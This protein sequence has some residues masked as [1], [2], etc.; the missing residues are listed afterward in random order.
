MPNV[1][2]TSD[3]EEPVLPRVYGPHV[4]PSTL[5]W[6]PF[7]PVELALGEDKPRVICEAYD[8]DREH[9]TALLKIPAFQKAILDAREML[10]KEG[11]SF[12][13]KARMQA[14][15]LLKTS[16]DLIHGQHTPAN[17]KADL[18]KTTM[19]VAGYEP[20]EGD[21]SVIAP[22]QINIQL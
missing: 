11:M 17:V 8:I 4:D 20:K 6:P 5:G 19:R 16:W 2:S 13:I 10:S 22:L 14:E 1:V 3:T 12:R 21:R 15:A 7:L 9:F 18:I